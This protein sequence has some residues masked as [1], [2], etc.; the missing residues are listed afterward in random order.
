[1][2]AASIIEK[3]KELSRSSVVARLIIEERF[4]PIAT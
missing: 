1:M 4:C 2:V 3:K